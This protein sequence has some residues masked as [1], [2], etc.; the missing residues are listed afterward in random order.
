MRAEG[1]LYTNE[2]LGTLPYRRCTG[3]PMHVVLIA[4]QY[5]LHNF[6]Y[7]AIVRILTRF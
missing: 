2:G 7:Q 5:L 1:L 3:T 4:L 6:I